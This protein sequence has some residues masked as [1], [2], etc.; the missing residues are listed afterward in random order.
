MHVEL[1]KK[2]ALLIAKHDKTVIDYEAQIKKQ[3]KQLLSLQ[4]TI[5]KQQEDVVKPLIEQAITFKRDQQER[6]ENQIE[7]S[8]HVRKLTAILKFPNLCE[9][10][11]RISH[12]RMPETEQKD[13]HKKAVLTLRQ[14]DLDD[15]QD[16][17]TQRIKQLQCG[18]SEQL[19]MQE[20]LNGTS[21][22]VKN[23]SQM[24]FSPQNV[25]LRFNS[26]GS[27][28]SRPDISM[29]EIKS[30]DDCSIA[31]RNE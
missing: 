24:I 11:H 23:K 4:K 3:R 1:E 16:N 31:S 10:F 6:Q 30:L 5:T 25:K 29:I 19:E 7:L 15:D 22:E 13:A 2:H 21:R 26:G 28:S 18:I 17:V 8:G 20:R 9:Q 14:I 12:E 27:V